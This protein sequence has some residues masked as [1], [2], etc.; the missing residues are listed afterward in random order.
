MDEKNHWDIV[1]DGGSRTLV[2]RILKKNTD[3]LFIFL[4][5]D[6][7]TQKNQRKKPISCGHVRNFR[8]KYLFFS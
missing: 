3:F 2:V 5:T 6:S 4:F 1:G 8:K 7:E